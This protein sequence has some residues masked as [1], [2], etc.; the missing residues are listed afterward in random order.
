[1]RTP[2]YLSLFLVL[3]GCG[4]TDRRVGSGTDARVPD[5]SLRPARPGL[6]D[7]GGSS[8]AGVAPG[9]ET[10]TGPRDDGPSDPVPRF[11][12]VILQN[13][14]GASECAQRG[15][16]S[17][18]LP[19]E[20]GHYAASILTPTQYPFEV[21]GIGYD[22]SPTA[23]D[24]DSRLPHEA[25]VFVVRDGEALP[26]SPSETHPEMQTFQLA[27]GD[28]ADFRSVDL[29]LERPITLQAGESV[30]VSIQMAINDRGDFSVC[31]GSCVSEAAALSGV[32]YWSNAPS[33]PFRWADLVGD[34]G[35]SSNYMTRVH[36]SPL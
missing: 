16:I 10:G 13:V 24:C 31:M 11:G 36:G 32:D 14:P 22:I 30:V 20:A 1:M 4:D 15:R 3:V 27:A 9:R 34:F 6:S 21:T 5:D 18:F 12:D 17:P 26:S 33:E 35:F 23:S 19:D 8:D 25:Q 2:I 29:P 7:A 28:S